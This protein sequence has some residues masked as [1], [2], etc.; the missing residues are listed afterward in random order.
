MPFHD[1]L[2]D[3]VFLYFSNACQSAFAL[4][5]DDSSEGL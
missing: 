2:D 4:I 3:F 5:K 1:A